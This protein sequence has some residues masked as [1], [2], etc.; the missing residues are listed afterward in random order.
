MSFTLSAEILIEIP[1]FDVDLMQIVWHGHY[2]KY[3]ELTRCKLFNNI[4]Y[5]YQKMHESGYYWPIVD[6]RVKYVK[7]LRFEQSICVKASLVEYLNR[8][9][10]AY[11]ISDAK[12]GEKLTEAYSI[13]VA[14]HIETNQMCYESP[15]ILLQKLGINNVIMQ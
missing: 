13:Q 7:P 10:I 15:A 1:F 14:V 12:S 4:D 6:M 8:V 2:L 3:F 5:G 9:K 11:L